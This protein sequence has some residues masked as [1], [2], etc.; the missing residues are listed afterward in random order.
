[1]DPASD[2]QGGPDG[3]GDEPTPPPAAPPPSGDAEVVSL[4]KFRGKH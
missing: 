1:V 4:A 2:A 3:G